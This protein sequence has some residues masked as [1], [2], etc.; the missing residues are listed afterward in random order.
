MCFVNKKYQYLSLLLLLTLFSC[1]KDEDVTAP[2][3]TF[4]NP[5]ENQSFTVYDYVNVKASVTD[6]T[7]L[8]AVSVTLLDA[9]HIPVHITVPVSVT[10]ASMN[11]NMQYLLDNIHLESGIYFMMITAS[12]GE[13]DTHAYRQI[14]VSAIPKQLKAVYVVSSAGSAQT[15]LSYIDSTFSNIIPFH[16]FSGDHLG[17]GISS[18]Y[19]QAFECGNYTGDFIGLD[20][21]FNSNHFLYPAIPSSAPYFTGFK[22]DEQQ[23]YI[24]RYDGAIRGYDHDGAGTFTASAISG[25]YAQHMFPFS[26]RLLAEEKDQ[27]SS[28][29]KLVVYFDAGGQEQS[30]AL[31]QDVT[32]FCQ[33]D[34]TN[35]FVF[36]NSA[37]QGVIQLYDKTSNNLW[38]PYPF[39]LATGS[40]LSVLKLDPDTYLIAHSNGTIYKYQ[41]SVNSLTTYMTGFTAVKLKMDEVNG[42]LYVVEANKISTFAYPSLSPMNTVTSAENILDVHLLYNR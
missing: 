24:A 28:A 25:Y 22:N 13:H 30:C 27:I 9:A 36:G 33:K 4:T 12:D 11:V 40:I 37:G 5:I 23:C 17:S 16:T 26:D 21:Q 10:S 8:E 6:E 1:K 15:D 19:Q 29:K 7:R 41:Y 14:Y 35:I 39:P 20:L 2:K 38:S 32:E 18:Y 3:V 42:V 34:N 31:P